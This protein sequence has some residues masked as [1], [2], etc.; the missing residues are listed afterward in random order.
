MPLISS[1][2]VFSEPKLRKLSTSDSPRLQMPYL[3][4]VIAIHY[5]YVGPS[6]AGKVVLRGNRDGTLQDA[7]S[8]DH[9]VAKWVESSAFVRLF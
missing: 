2:P 8:V 4:E 7:D 9:G 6:S 5:K 3:I 1:N